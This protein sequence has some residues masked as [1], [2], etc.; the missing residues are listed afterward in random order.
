LIERRPL[1]DDEEKRRVELLLARCDVAEGLELPVV[2]PPAGALPE[3]RLEPLI[4][5]QEGDILGY[6]A[7]EGWPIPE[8]TPI[9]HPQW[10][11]KSIGRALVEAATGLCRERGLRRW[12]MVA[13]SISGSAQ[14][15]S[16]AVAARYDSSEYRMALDP[17]LMPQVPA[18]PDLRLTKVEGESEEF[19]RTL[20]TAYDD[21]LDQVRRWAA[22]QANVPNVELYL[23]EQDEAPVGTVRL[24]TIGFEA[25][26]TALGVLPE[27]RRQ[28]LGR[29]TVL[30]SVQNLL[31]EGWEKIRIE[32]D[33]T[34]EA[35]Y[36]LY[37]ACG[38]RE[39]RTYRYYELIT[40][41]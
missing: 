33:T 36:G 38:F 37:R 17:A 18:R 3:G 23:V 40:G 5:R 19:A 24:I 41:N 2:I 6:L 25:Y 15:F 35:A 12:L 22:E 4:W 20:A 11:R 30:S 32:V 9:V 29:W 14:P 1:L 31:S 27:C 21:P 10:R 8:G 26:V 28:G 34:N 39:T 13:D 7:L 16:E